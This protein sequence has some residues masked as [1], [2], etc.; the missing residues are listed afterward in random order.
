MK[1]LSIV[2]T[3]PEAIKLAP[4][5]RALRYRGVEAVVCLTGQHREMLADSLPQLG[6]RADIELSGLRSGQTINQTIGAA[7]GALDAMLAQVRPD[8]V[9]VQGDTTT[10]LAGSLAAFNR[11]IP[12][13]HV[14]AGLRTHDPR[15][16]WPEETNR[17]A[18]DV[19]CDLLFAPTE[20]ARDN[21]KRENLAGRIFVTGN[22]GIDAVREAARRL[23]RDGELRRAID[24]TLPA[25]TPGKRLVLVTGHRR[26]SFGQ[27]LLEVCSAL[28]ILSRRDDV[29]VLYALHLNPEIEGPVRRALGDRR[30]IRLAPPQS[31]L[32]FV[33]L[34]QRCH[35]VV[36]DS[37]GVQ[38]E[39]PALAKPVVVT[40]TE[41]ERS[42]AL[43]AG[44]AQLVGTDSAAILHA[45]ER[46]LDDPAHYARR[47]VRRLPFGD[48]RASERI[49]DA[50]LG[51]PVAEF[52]TPSARAPRAPAA[53]PSE[54]VLDGRTFL[55]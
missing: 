25:L 19:V 44:G 16:P 28:K 47:A 46:L 48:G 43:T 39:A 38:E 32:A 23:R 22:T 51:G 33:R 14:E 5:V 24:A 34:L 2:G 15:R 53:A 7:M 18:I 8:R 36:T 54:A 49:V 42:E 20:R 31:Y 30:N 17:R 13:A 11:Q 12:V 4:V 50:L 45:V 21:L 52:K 9:L 35:L 40:R 37:G 27:R 3:R 41:T 1:V 26:E 6:L 55:A 29:E 10:A